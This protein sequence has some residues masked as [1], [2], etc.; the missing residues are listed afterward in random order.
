MNKTAIIALLICTA[1]FAQQKGSF[2][3]ARDKKTYKTVTIGT[4]TWMAQNLDYGGKNDDIGA[5][6]GK[7]AENCKKY[8]TLYT[9]KEAK[10]VCPAGWHLPTMDEWKILV[11]FAGG[12]EIAGKKL[13]SKSEWKASDAAERRKHDAINKSRNDWEAEERIRNT[14]TITFCKYTTE[15][16]TARGNVIKTEHDD[17]VTDEF[18]FSALPIGGGNGCSIPRSQYGGWWTATEDRNEMSNSIAAYYIQMSNDENGVWL[19]N[20]YCKTLNGVRC[21]KN[22]GAATQNA[23]PEATAKA[24]Q[25]ETTIVQNQTQEQ[26]VKTF[27]PSFDCAK[28]STPTENAICSDADLAKLDNTLNREYSKASSVC[29]QG[30]KEWVSNRNTCSSNIQCLRNSYILRIQVLKSCQ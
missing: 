10:E 9:W 3:D 15:E 13:K 7:K 21:I 27:K 19:S 22:A 14:P 17:C 8:G 26:Q 16:T 29:K 5:C 30:Q 12:A 6:P 1:V 24:T 18:G 11:K 2:T 25:T 23:I 20:Y 4:Q 28:A